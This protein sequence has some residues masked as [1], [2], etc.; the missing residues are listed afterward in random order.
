[1]WGRSGRFAASAQ[2]AKVGEIMSNRN[3]LLSAAA[4]AAVLC[5][6]SQAALGAG[7]AIRE[8]SA[9]GQGVSF[10]SGPTGI[11]DISHMYFNPSTMAFQS[12]HQALSV[13]SYIEVS[14][15]FKSG[16]AS[17]VFGSP[18]GTS[19][20]FTG[21][22]DIGP[23]AVVPATYA[24]L[25]VSE[26]FKVGLAIT[27]PF[28]LKNTYSDGW[29]G[30]YHALDSRLTTINVNPTVSYRLSPNFAI[31]AGFVVQYI[32]AKLSNAIDFGSIAAASMVPGA[33]PGGQ[34]GRG[35]LRGDDVGFGFT[36]GMMWQPRDYLRF[37][38]SY[39]SYIDHEIDGKAE[40]DRGTS[41]VGDLIANV[42][43]GFRNTGIKASAQTPDIANIGFHYDIN[44][45]FSIMGMAEWTNWS[46]FDELRIRF[47]NPAQPD[48]V[49]DESWND[50]WYFALGGEYRATDELTL[51]AGVAFDESPI[52]DGTRT[53]RIP[54]EDRYWV[55]VGATYEV[56]DW[57]SVSA[58]YTHIFIP[59]PKL[60]LGA[61]DPGSTFRGNLSGRYDSSV[62]I[63]AVQG[64][65]KF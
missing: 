53:P 23:S 30:R 42:S 27:S 13:A 14:G 29:I 12:G 8:Q 58:G 48:S 51:R 16:S 64:R 33:V 63:V 6:T 43:G 49:T 40:F 21:N 4:G 36:A 59:D 3:R 22:D 2:H 52:P 11:S 5:L 62:D 1:M 15:E 65:I 57:M 17:T 7:Y 61:S 35:K 25:D 55:S 60:D 19:F 28:G 54:G 56:S 39:R 31:G 20:G 10:A 34:D 45:Q 41:G 44:D 46:R 9:T 24:M 47:D 50:S 26:D 38:A 18:I 32:S 37:G